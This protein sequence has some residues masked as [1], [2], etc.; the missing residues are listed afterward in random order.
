MKF[1]TV[2]EPPNPPAD[3]A[4][5]AELL[6]FVRDEFDWNILLFAPF[7]LL[8]RR[9]YLGLAIYVTALAVTILAMAAMDADAA[10]ISIAVVAL[11]IVFAYEISEFERQRLSS[12][13][14]IMV[15]TVSG[16]TRE[17]CERRF[18]ENWLPHQPMIRRQLGP[19]SGDTGEGPAPP[20]ADGLARAP[21]PRHG[22]DGGLLGWLVPGRRRR[23]TSGT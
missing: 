17:E 10:W 6:R 16:K 13:G 15:G 18:F 2:H 11:H 1:Y 5:R 21:E 23:T 4:D 12:L 8:F 19:A 14:W 7:A 22:R 9:L 3:R 20:R